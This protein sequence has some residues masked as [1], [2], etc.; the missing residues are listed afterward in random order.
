MKFSRRSDLPW[1]GT[2]VNMMWSDLSRVWRIFQAHMASTSKLANTTTRSQP[3]SPFSNPKKSRLKSV[4]Y[5]LPMQGCRCH[6]H[7]CQGYTMS[8]TVDVSMCK[9]NFK[10]IFQNSK[11]DFCLAGRPKN[12][13]IIDHQRVSC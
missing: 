8:Q 10:N 13:E 2:R 12:T 7:K 1:T 5:I 11:E 3:P 4:T 9:M 6:S